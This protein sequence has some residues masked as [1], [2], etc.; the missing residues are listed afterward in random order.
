MKQ[1]L[2]IRKF[3]HMIR[4]NFQQTYTEEEAQAYIQFL[5]HTN[6]TID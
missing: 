4:K 2:A 1:L 5:Q 6:G 3:L